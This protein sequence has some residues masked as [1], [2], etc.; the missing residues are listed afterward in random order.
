MNGHWFCSHHNDV[1]NIRKPTGRWDDRKGVTC[2][3]CHQPACDWV[4][5]QDKPRTLDPETLAKGFE[6]IRKAVL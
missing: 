1:V 5:D 4:P 6:Q 3:V 2:P